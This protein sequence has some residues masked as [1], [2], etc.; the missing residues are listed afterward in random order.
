MGSHHGNMSE[1]SHGQNM[2]S[3]YLKHKLLLIALASSLPA[4]FA[5]KFPE[6]KAAA[7]ETNKIPEDVEAQTQLIV[8]RNSKK[9]KGCY[10]KLWSGRRLGK[11]TIKISEMTSGIESCQEACDL[12]PDCTALSFGFPSTDAR[13][14]NC[15][16]TNFKTEFQ[17][18]SN[19]DTEINPQFSV[20][21]RHEYCPE[22]RILTKN[23]N[24]PVLAVDPF[25]LYPA[26]KYYETNTLDKQNIPEATR[27][28][29]YDTQEGCYRQALIT[30]KLQNRYIRLSKTTNNL[31]DCES[32]CT[33]EL[34]FTCKGFSYR[35]P[36][37]AGEVLNCDL[38]DQD[39]TTLDTYTDFYPNTNTYFYE[40]SGTGSDCRTASA[41]GSKCYESFKSSTKHYTY[42]DYKTST[43]VEGCAEECK[44]TSWCNSISYRY[45]Y[46]SATDIGNCLLSDTGVED[47][48]DPEDLV[49]DSSWDIYRVNR[50]SSCG[51]NGNPYP[52]T[53]RPTRPAD[54]AEST[55]A[56]YRHFSTRPQDKLR[57][58]T[59][60]ECGE[61]CRQE[62]YCNSFSYSQSGRDCYL[63]T[64]RVDELQT[65]DIARD[66]SW[67]IFRPLFGGSCG[68]GGGGGYYPDRPY[69]P[70]QGTQRP[71]D[72][73]PPQR[74]TDNRPLAPDSP[75]GCFRIYEAR[76]RL[77]RSAARESVSARDLR[78]CEEK[79]EREHLFT[80]RSFSFT[81]DYMARNCDL[82]ELGA[83]DLSLGRDL[84]RDQYSDVYEKI[85]SGA[86][87]SGSGGGN[88]I[89][90]YIRCSNFAEPEYRLSYG[91]TRELTSARDSA[92]C[93]EQCL[94]ATRYSCKIFAYKYGSSGSKNCELSDRDL[95]DIRVSSDL[96][97]DRDWDV[98]ERTRYSGECRDQSSIHDN[99][100][101]VI[102]DRLSCYT[103]YRS[104]T[105]FR[106]RAVVERRSARDEEECARECDY[107]RGSGQYQCNAFSYRRNYGSNT[108]NCVLSDSYGRD[109]D[110][111]LTYE[112]DYDV[113]EFSG[114]GPHCR[115]DNDIDSAG[116]Y[117]VNGQRCLRGGCRLNP[118][119]NYWYC[120]VA[121][122]RGWDYCCR[123][124]HR[125]GYSEG[126]R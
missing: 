75:S 76:Y 22:Q 52:P 114:R 107:Y 104:D 30:R 20:H 102:I 11:E 68:S 46:N 61:L 115:N 7:E 74:P 3:K 36:Q 9:L 97:R 59:L 88:Y 109:I 125:C 100:D 77:E 119:V 78:D 81:S 93:E 108:D 39:T 69:N 90:D 21:L 87:G 92:D 117:T 51:G 64:L 38:T 96:D 89:H 63:S 123:P 2:S 120:E 6:D 49:K 29:D 47:L 67:D 37:S 58:S 105:S 80:C 103:K 94:L 121:E 124:E 19:W 45:S 31:A 126:F 91:I 27:R 17:S 1:R 82:S 4:S 35:A 50:G 13:E 71:S 42:R 53:S 14:G 95:R 33:R 40:R 122:D 85:T 54:C 101:S 113:Y 66:S 34:S 5:F 86:C 79:C 18:F 23:S 118:D 8:L 57:A 70:G 62:K 73:T 56:G 26:K 106:S 110:V 28:R 24:S 12:Q 15:E 32:L 84:V 43:S 65:R 116:E 41:L 72:N 16:M 112:R 48:R 55:R 25:P 98:F 10:T 111:D 83:R 44:R 99:G 60:Y